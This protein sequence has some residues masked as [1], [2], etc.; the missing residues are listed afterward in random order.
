MPSSQEPP[1]AAELSSALRLRE[2]LR[3]QKSRRK[4][5]WRV[6]VR[7]WLGCRSP[8]AGGRCTRSMREPEKGCPGPHQEREGRLL[9]HGEDPR[10]CFHLL[11]W[12]YQAHNPQLGQD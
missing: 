11:A 5:E 8:L 12:I 7:P 2:A 10:L 3:K 9:Q 6:E 4:G 1:T